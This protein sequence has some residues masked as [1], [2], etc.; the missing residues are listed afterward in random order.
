[1]SRYTSI[2]SVFTV[3]C[4]A[5]SLGAQSTSNNL[6]RT[7]SIAVLTTGAE[8]SASPAT[9]VST[10]VVPAQA[11]P[12]LS[13][14]PTREN[15]AAGLRLRTDGFAP[16]PVPSPGKNSENTALMIVGGAALIVGSIIGGDAGSL[17]MIGGAGVGL[18]G[19]WQYLR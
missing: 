13:L 15:A 16:M 14:A 12:A 4:L 6:P 8:R 3:L 7:D 11:A 9:A 5:S 2:A 18:Y 1:M 19:L 10:Q 17:I